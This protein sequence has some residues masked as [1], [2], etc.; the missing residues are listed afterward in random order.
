MLGLCATLHTPR[1]MPISRSLKP[2]PQTKRPCVKGLIPSLRLLGYD[3]NL[4]R[5]DLAGG[6]QVTGNVHKKDTAG[7]WSL[8]FLCV[9]SWP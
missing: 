5:W 2:P 6:N 9:T 8:F 3:R 7:T 1:A 4:K